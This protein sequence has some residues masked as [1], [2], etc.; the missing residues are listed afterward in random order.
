MK[1]TN[2][3]KEILG[4]LVVDIIAVGFFYLLFFVWVTSFSL[5]LLVACIT[6]FVAGMILLEMWSNRIDEE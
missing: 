2:N 4:C 5:S 3:T 1:V 6:G